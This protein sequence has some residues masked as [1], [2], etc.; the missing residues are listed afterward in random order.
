[1]TEQKVKYPKPQTERPEGHNP[2]KISENEK[3]HK[4]VEAHSPEVTA[5]TKREK[6]ISD[7]IRPKKSEIEKQIEE[8]TLLAR[9]IKAVKKW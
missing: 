4:I 2:N 7:I 9:I 6:R 8:Q 1:M 3:Y 5:I